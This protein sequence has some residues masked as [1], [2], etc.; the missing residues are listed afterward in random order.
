MEWPEVPFL[1][2]PYTRKEILEKVHEAL[3]RRHRT[4]KDLATDRRR[5]PRLK[6]K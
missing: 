6:G 5:K 4:A 3:E 1:A 2:K